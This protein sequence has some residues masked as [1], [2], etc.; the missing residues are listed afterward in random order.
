MAE[1]ATRVR[2]IFLRIRCLPVRQAMIIH[3]YPPHHVSMP[4]IRILFTM[5]RIVPAM[6]SGPLLTTKIW[7]TFAAMPMVM[8]W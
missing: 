4:A 2:M 1:D 8:N 6:M 5:I 7:C 3:W